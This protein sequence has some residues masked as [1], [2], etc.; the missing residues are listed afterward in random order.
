MR[1]ARAGH[2]RPGTKLGTELSIRGGEEGR[3]DGRFRALLEAAPDAM[4][5]VGGDG[6]IIFVNAQTEKMFG[7]SRDEMLGNRVEM[8]MPPR[9]R[10][11]HPVHRDAYF[12]KPSARAMGPG[13]EFYGLRKDGTEFPVEISLS[14]LR[15]E[16]GSLVSSSIRDVTARRLAEEKMLQSEER[17][18]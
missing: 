9:F 13:L 8:L 5:I 3:S 11:L 10:Q 14:P 15:T 16:E 17:F 4:V 18:R 12:E 7:Y 6:R 2:E 1:M